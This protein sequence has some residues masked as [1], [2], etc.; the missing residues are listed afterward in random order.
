MAVPMGTDVILTRDLMP[1]T[2]RA[3]TL[4]GPRYAIPIEAAKALKPMLI[5]FCSVSLHFLQIRAQ[6]IT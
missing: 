6:V 1:R 4:S 5:A 2:M 3:T